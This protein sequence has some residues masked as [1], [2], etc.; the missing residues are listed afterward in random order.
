MK[1]VVAIGNAS[2]FVEPLEATALGMIGTRSQLL[3]Q[4]LMETEGQ[5]KVDQV[6]LYNAHHRRLWDTIRDFLACHYRFNHH[7]ST[8]F[9]RHCQNETDLA[10]AK[11]MVEYY[12]EYGP[13]GTWGPLKVDPLC[14]FGPNGYLMILV[15]QKVPH[16]R[17]Y[18]PSEKE[19]DTWN[20]LVRANIDT[21]RGAMTVAE[22]LRAL[23]VPD[24]PAESG[25]AVARAAVRA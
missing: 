3:A 11:P 10:G 12:Q 22:S 14:G 24:V 6:D 25:P 13:T 2:G 1:N 17:P 18:T 20:K 4:V 16:K 9:W 15:G 23:G 19:R 8:P 21:A 7:L 5:V